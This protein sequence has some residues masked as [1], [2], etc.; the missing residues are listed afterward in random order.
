MKS[1][2]F[3]IA[4]MLLSSLLS[5]M[6]SA[7]CPPSINIG[8]VSSGTPWSYRALPGGKASLIAPA[9]HEYAQL[10]ISDIADPS[11]DI[12]GISALS[13][14]ADKNLRKRVSDWAKCH[15]GASEAS[16][17]TK[18]NN[19]PTPMTG[20]LPSS[21]GDLDVVTPQV[22]GCPRYLRKSLVEWRRVGGNPESTSYV[23]RN[24]SQRILK[25]TFRE[26]GQNTDTDTLNPGSEDVVSI[27][28]GRVPAFVVRD[29]K[30]L[31]DFNMAHST[32][33]DLMQKSLQCSLSIRPQ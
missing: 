2:S 27:S 19:L 4:A 1:R 25:V 26:N 21:S 3:P 10:N 18:P 23:V 11:T 7:A 28:N 14:Y 15:Q 24:I 20:G 29:F 12:I 17:T 32:N 16:T 22:P 31:V 6:A 5:Q 33:R 8:G 9:G 30:E 13:L